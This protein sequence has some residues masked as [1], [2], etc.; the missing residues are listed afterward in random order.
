MDKPILQPLLSLL[1]SRKFLVTVA[2]ILVDVLVALVPELESVQGELLTVFTVLGSILVA[3][4]AYE[5]AAAKRNIV[6]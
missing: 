4:I 2:T 5:D 6:G 1:Y 3:S